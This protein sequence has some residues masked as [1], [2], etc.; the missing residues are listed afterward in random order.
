MVVAIHSPGDEAYEKLQFYAAIRV[1]EV[2]IVDRDTKAPEIHVLTGDGYEKKGPGPEGWL[3]SDET[4]LELKAE[5]AGKLS[6]RIAGDE[7]T[8]ADLPED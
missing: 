4:G 8:R 7:S 3:A 6:V 1:P 2:W 5:K